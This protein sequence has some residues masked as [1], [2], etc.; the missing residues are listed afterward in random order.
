[1]I[2]FIFILLCVGSLLI[3]YMA[4]VRYYKKRILSQKAIGSLFIEDH[5]DQP[6]NLYLAI[7]NLEELQQ[8]G[9]EIILQVKRE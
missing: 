4:G 2:L 9:S 3:G 1:M 6:L 8:A 7:E 5:P